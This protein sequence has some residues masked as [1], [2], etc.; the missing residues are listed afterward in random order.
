MTGKPIGLGDGLA[1]CRSKSIDSDAKACGECRL[2]VEISGDPGFD[3][4]TE[5]DRE[6]RRGNGGNGFVP[7][8]RTGELLADSNNSTF[9]LVQREL[10]N[11]ALAD[12]AVKIVVHCSVFLFRF[13]HNPVPTSNIISL[14]CKKSS[15]FF[16]FFLIFYD[17][18][19]KS[20]KIAINSPLR[21]IRRA[22]T[23]KVFC[24]I[25]QVSSRLIVS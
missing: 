2:T 12:A 22:F 17:F 14:F 25:R 21:S 11:R 20:H 10:L 8:I 13:R 1:R 15:P 24:V 23:D 18:F 6:G 19:A 9:P 16:H 4:K 7:V 3:F 5:P